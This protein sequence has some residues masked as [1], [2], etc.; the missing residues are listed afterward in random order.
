[1]VSRLRETTEVAAELGASPDGAG[2]PPVSLNRS[3]REIKIM[4][5]NTSAC[6]ECGIQLSASEMITMRKCILCE[7]QTTIRTTNP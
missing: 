6:Y 3:R 2:A 4:N 1:M 5:S 7:L